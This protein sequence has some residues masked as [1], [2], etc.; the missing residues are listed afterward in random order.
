[1]YSAAACSLKE[2]TKNEACLSCITYPEKKPWLS[3]DERTLDAWID[4]ASVR[5]QKVLQ[6]QALAEAQEAPQEQDQ[7]QVNLAVVVLL[8]RTKNE[9][10]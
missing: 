3:S 1:M 8:D 10:T 9:R 4:L 5:L 2:K 7:G 6:L